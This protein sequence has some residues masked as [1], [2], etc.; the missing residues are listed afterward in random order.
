MG[1][2]RTDAEIRAYVRALHDFFAGRG[3]LDRVRICADEPA[4]LDHFIAQVA[5]LEELGPRFKFKLAVNHFEFMDALPESVVDYVPLLNLAG[6]DLALTASLRDR[7]APKGGRVSWYVCCVPPRPNTFCKSPLVEGQLHGWITFFLRLDGF[8]RWNYC[9]WP[10]HP[11]NAGGL[12]WRPRSWEMGDMFFVLPGF[13]GH[14]VETLRSEALRRAVQDYE[15]LKMAEAL[16]PEAE[17]SALF[18]ACHDKIFAPGIDLPALCAAIGAEEVPPAE[19]LY[20]LDPKV[21][22]ECRRMV[23]ERVEAVL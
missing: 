10:Q 17:A 11:W 9:L 6:R 19:E 13:D 22:E 4:N 18:A 5:L 12:A 14:P 21:Y 23:L 15:L 1:Y 20:S 2:L 3:V 16:L 8:L 7:V